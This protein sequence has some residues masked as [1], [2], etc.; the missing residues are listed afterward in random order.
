[1]K[2]RRSQLA[3]DDAHLIAECGDA[4]IAFPSRRIVAARLAEGIDVLK[5]PQDRS[6]PG[7]RAGLPP[8]A[9]ID[10]EQWVAWD[11]GLLIGKRALNHAWVLVRLPYANTTLRLALRTGRC[12][13]VGEPGARAPLPRGIFSTRVGAVSSAFIVDE[14]LGT[15]AATVGR[16]CICIDVQ[17][18]WSGYELQLSAKSLGIASMLEAVP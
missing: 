17:Q 5:S 6:K 10:G 3:S 18:L 15:G 14:A 16:L 11:M 1:M 12:L 7:E 13:A 8:V 4:L 9:V 2:R